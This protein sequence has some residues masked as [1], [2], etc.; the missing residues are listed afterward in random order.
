MSLPACASALV[1]RLLSL[2]VCVEAS[3][4]PSRPGRK[5]QEEMRPDFKTRAARGKGTKV[6]DRFSGV[7]WGGVGWGE[8]PGRNLSRVLYAT[9][10]S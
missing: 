2:R 10:N 3:Y 5:S 6:A 9:D 8:E 7:G 4:A 1:A